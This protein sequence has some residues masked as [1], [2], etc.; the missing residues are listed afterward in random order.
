LSNLL[1][2]TICTK[3]RLID[4]YRQSQQSYISRAAHAI[5]AGTVPE[6]P[7]NATDFFFS[8][9]NHPDKIANT[10]LSLVSHRIPKYLNI[11]PLRDI[12][13]LTPMHRG[14]TGIDNLNSKCQSFFQEG[15][16]KISIGSKQFYLH[17]KVMQTRNNYQK[18]VFN[19]DVGFITSIS[20]QSR[21]IQVT[22]EGSRVVEYKRSECDEIVLAYATSIHKFQGSECPC[23]IIPLHQ[24]HA[25]M[26]Q[27]NLLY[28][29]VTRGKQMVVILGTLKAYQMAVRNNKQSIRHTLL[30]D[31]IVDRASSWK[32]LPC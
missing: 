24:T 17:D 22:Y 32:Q 2:T 15:K 29:A 10:V 30:I 13:V 5:N 1:D 31:Q 25:I 4:V 8:E 9:I 21:T 28:T 26:L 19:G 3:I 27:R 7:E 18:H 11:H 23:V 12:Q 16:Q 20:T 6:V 14:V